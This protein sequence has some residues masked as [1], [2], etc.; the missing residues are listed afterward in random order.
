M[1][2]LT[3]ILSI[4]FVIGLVHQ[5]VV[6]AEAMKEKKAAKTNF[7]AKKKHAVGTTATA[8]T[9]APAPSASPAA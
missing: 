2:K 7:S 5:G 8:Q 9:P 4:L 3:A 1:K 6:F